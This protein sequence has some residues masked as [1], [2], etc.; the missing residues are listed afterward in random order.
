MFMGEAIQV[1]KLKLRKHSKRRKVR[2]RRVCYIRKSGHNGIC[3]EWEIKDF[4]IESWTQNL[5]K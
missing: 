5:K 1:L 4:T 2:K 3:Y